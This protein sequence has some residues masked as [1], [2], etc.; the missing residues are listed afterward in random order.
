MFDFKVSVITPVYNAA[1]F[2]RNAVESAVSLEEV[3]EIILVEDGSPDNALEICKEL[4]Q[5]FE[6]VKLFQHPNGENRGA[7]ASRNLGIEKAIFEYIAFLDADDWYLPNRF[8]AEKELFKN[9]EVDGV[10]GATGFYEQGQILENKLTTFD[11]KLKPE[12]LLYYY[13]SYKGRFTTDAITFKKSLL[14][15]SGVFKT[16]L[17][18]HQDT[19]LWYRLAHFG[20]L[21]PG[22]IDQPIAIRRVHE[23]NRISSRNK[24]TRSLFHKEVFKDFINK[25]NVD[26]RA[27]KIIINRYVSSISGNFFIKM[28]HFSKV[29]MKNS[30]L[31]KIYIK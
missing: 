26:S 6:K 10:Y 4:E 24:K 30:H 29:L 20:N 16:S 19:H 12:D 9:P 5:E 8:Q 25:E 14:K 27:L 21:Y 1:E 31:I 15:K 3:G 11:Y 22:L 2:I 17:K 7:G 13:V 23:N 18:L 28:F